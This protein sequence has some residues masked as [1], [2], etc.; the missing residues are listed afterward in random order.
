MIKIYTFISPPTLSSGSYQVLELNQAISYCISFLL[1]QNRLLQRQWLKAA[2]FC[3]LTVFVVQVSEHGLA[4]SSTQAAVK[5]WLPRVLLD[6]WLEKKLLLSLFRLL[7]ELIRLWLSDWGPWLPTGYWLED[8][9]G[10]L[11]HGPIHRQFTAWLCASSKPPG[12]SLSLCLSVSH[13][14]HRFICNKTPWWEWHPVT[15]VIFCWSE[16]SHR[17]YL[18][19]GSWYM[20]VTHQGLPQRVL[21][22]RLI[23]KINSKDTVEMKRSHW[24]KQK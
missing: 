3:Y 17:F 4:E 7:T 19:L 10:S 9:H 20:G 5:Y 13:L 14:L 18:Y 2:H 8:S 15:F 23:P 6:A 21:A 22:V 1:L 16:S 11:P 12:E 24:F